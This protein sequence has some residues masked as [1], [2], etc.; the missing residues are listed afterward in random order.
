MKAK[1]VTCYPAI[2]AVILA[3]FFSSSC[4]EGGQAAGWWQGEQQRI[5]LSHE[6]ELKRYRFEQTYSRDYEEFEKLRQSTE[7]AATLLKSLRKERLALTEE[8]ELS[9]ARWADFRESMIRD[10]RQRA[11]GRTFETFSVVSGRTFEKV[12][13][14]EIDDAGVTIRHTDGSARLRYADLDAS[15]RLLFGLEADL[16]QAAVQQESQ[17]AA[18]YEGWIETRMARLEEKK[19]MSSLVAK[20]D[21]SE[22]RQKRAEQLRQQIAASNARP[23]AKAATSFGNSS[24][25]YSNHTSSYRTY[26]PTYRYV[27]YASP[28]YRSTY[29][30]RTNPCFPA[31]TNPPRRLPF[32]PRVGRVTNPSRQ[33]FAETTLPS[34]P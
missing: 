1:N 15:Q 10:Q 28:T 5:E 22:A 14:S 25:R 13:V 33:S 9:E 32:T 27:Y 6:L 24:W 7:N 16:A 8:I 3:G 31:G 17:D 12:S 4:K 29:G 11:I 19:E 20:R 2:A 30:Y 21:E 18:E 26:R 23:L 34:I